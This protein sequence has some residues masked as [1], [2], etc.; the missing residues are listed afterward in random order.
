MPPPTPSEVGVFEVTPLQIMKLKEN[1]WQIDIKW[2]V[3]MST[4]CILSMVVMMAMSANLSSST[5]HVQPGN[6]VQKIQ[7]SIT[8]EVTNSQHDNPTT[9]MDGTSFWQNFSLWK[10]WWSMTMWRNNFRWGQKQ[11]WSLSKE[12]SGEGFCWQFLKIE[13]WSNV[14]WCVVETKIYLSLIFSTIKNIQVGY[15]MMM[16]Q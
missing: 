3:W 4:L 1:A 14:I 2:N 8:K 6:D 11:G 9:S 15:W 7:W 13:I 10:Y 16:K 12:E 5:M